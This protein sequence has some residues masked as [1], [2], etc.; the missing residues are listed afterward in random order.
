MRHI[1]AWVVFVLAAY[2]LSPA[3]ALDYPTRPVRWIVPY[4][5]A[6]STDIIARIVGQYLSVKLGQSFFI[7][8]RPGA[9]ANIGTQAVVNAAPDGYTI[10]FVSPPNA[11]NATL[12]ENMTYN[13]LNDLAMVGGLVQLPNV[14]EVNP[15]FPAKTVA[16]FIAYA[17]ANPGKLNMASSGI[18]TSL[19]LTG[20]MFKAMTGIDMR[21]IPYRGAAPALTDLMAGQVD[22]IFDNIPSSIGYIGAG[23][24][25]ALGVTSA[26]RAALLPDTPSIGETVPG[27]DASIWFGVAA[28][29]NT[30]PEIIA[31]LNA[32]VNDALADPAIAARLAE[33]GCTTMPTTP[34]GFA[35]F[36]AAETVKWAKVV[37]ESGAT[38]K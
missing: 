10:L 13:F 9:G 14:M 31:K 38:A 35:D 28:P 37:K 3:C 1:L 7:D 34:A 5:P 24:L 32:A 20:E 33:L 12:Y 22:V 36:M 23:R 21:H 2:G 29:K 25:R 18:G 6:G 26:K 8:N 16:E 11:I 19:H 27:Y 15:D 4:T 30:P 17:K